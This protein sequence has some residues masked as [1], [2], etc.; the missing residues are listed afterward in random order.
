MLSSAEGLK[1][2]EQQ[3][4][5]ADRPAAWEMVV[6]AEMHG[7]TVLSVRPVGFRSTTSG[8]ARTQ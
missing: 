8:T 5:L 4:D 6:Q 1:L 3:W 2:L 7:D